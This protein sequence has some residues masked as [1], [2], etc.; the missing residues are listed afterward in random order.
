MA[1]QAAISMRLSVMY[2]DDSR[3]GCLRDTFVVQ[4]IRE[5][6]PADEREVFYSTGGENFGNIGILQFMM[7]DTQIQ[8][9][10]EALIRHIR[11][12]EICF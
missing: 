10:R 12:R 11:V 6:N 3:I 4:K 8:I 9:I 2:I 5:L 1:A 7:R